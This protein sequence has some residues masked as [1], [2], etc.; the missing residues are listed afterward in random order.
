MPSPALTS[1]PHA[2]RSSAAALRR[3]CRRALLATTAAAAT[4]SSSRQA[5]APPQAS[6]ASTACTRHNLTGATYKPRTPPPLRRRHDVLAVATLHSIVTSAPRTPP[7]C[8]PL[9]RIAE[10]PPCSPHDASMVTTTTTPSMPSRVH[11]AV[12]HQSSPRLST[13]VLCCTSS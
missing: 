10:P 9:L 4:V 3:P 12:E 7:P 1:L 8:L 2:A 13:S 6:T 11:Q 5:P